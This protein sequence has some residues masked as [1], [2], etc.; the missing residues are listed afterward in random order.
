MFFIILFGN[1]VFHKKRNEF[2]IIIIH[3]HAIL[4]PRLCQQTLRYCVRYLC[5]LLKKKNCLDIIIIINV[6]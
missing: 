4:F 2:N 3:A 1:R 6:Y 5:E